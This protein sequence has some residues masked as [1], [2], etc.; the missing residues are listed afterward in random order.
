MAGW[1]PPS[2]ADS[3]GDGGCGMYARRRSTIR[4]HLRNLLA[5]AVVLLAP[6]IGAGEL[7]GSLALSSDYLVHGLRR[8]AKEPALQAHV[9]WL[10][11]R[12]WSTGVW[13]STVELH[14][15]SGPR[16]ELDFYLATQTQLSRD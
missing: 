1:G 5:L 11:E 15:G 13:A 6:P 2:Y 10:G 3:P 16:Q 14:P 7:T 4:L 8:S 9:G 12:G